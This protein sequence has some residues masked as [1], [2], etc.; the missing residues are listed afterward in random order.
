MNLAM[1][2]CIYIYR[3]YLYWA[4]G[5][6]QFTLNVEL[7]MLIALIVYIYKCFKI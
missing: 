3:M 7:C 6:L 4:G 1:P 5:G 2:L